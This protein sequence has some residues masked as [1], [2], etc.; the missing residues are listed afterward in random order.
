[1][2]SR[3]LLC[4]PCAADLKRIAD[5]P[6]IQAV[7]ETARFVF[8]ASIGDY[9]CDSCSTDLGA[10]KRCAAATVLARGETPGAWEGDYVVPEGAADA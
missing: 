5:S 9:I 8:G 1:M 10:G 3:Q 2:A 6:D 4:P 7:G